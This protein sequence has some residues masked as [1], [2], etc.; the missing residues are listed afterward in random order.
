MKIAVVGAGIFGITV[1]RRLSES[2]KVSIFDQN[3]TILSA[4]SHANQLR[5]HRGY[6][7]PRSPETV[8]DLLSS[9]SEFMKDYAGAVVK[10]NKH[11]YAI[12]KRD[13]LVSPEQ[14]L[15][16]CNDLSLEH[17][18]VEN[19][20]LIRNESVSLI[21]KAIESSIDYEMLKSIA[22]SHLR[23]KNI[24]VFLGRRFFHEMM[25]EFDYVINCTYSSLNKLSPSLKDYQFEVCEK[26]LVELPEEFTKQSI[27]VMDGPFMCVDPYG[28]TTYSLLGNVVHAIHATNTGLFPYVPENLRNYVDS[29]LIR[30]P[31][32][33]NFEKF[34]S[35]GI[36]FVPALSQAKH[37]GSLYTI[38]SVLPRLDATD[39]RPT[40]V[41][42]Q[43][44]KIINVF[45]GKIDTCSIA[46]QQVMNHIELGS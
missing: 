31:K 40:I 33:T 26:I 3:N 10:D 11:Y 35:S 12:S 27:V 30:N 36:E 29:G 1:A 46:A 38:R 45:S 9:I 34:I 6:H 13:S 16:F 41:S 18:I 20:D 21:I 8:R 37:V 25:S 43:Q 15:E 39:A 2:H 4:A 22:S 32:V 44:E 19:H 42:K 7:Y 23:H 5:L 14:Y 17:E 24:S 28:N